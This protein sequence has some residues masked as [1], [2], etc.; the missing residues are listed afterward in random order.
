MLRLAALLAMAWAL[1][2]VPALCFAGVFLHPCDCGTSVDC[3]HEEDCSDDPCT[4]ALVR[5]DSQ[6][7]HLVLDILGT[8]AVMPWPEPVQ[9]PGAPFPAPA[10]NRPN[11][12]RPSGD[13]PLLI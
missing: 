3:A 1:M 11:L 13:L 10:V 12:P 6:G 7:G 4:D 5:Q 8:T 2:A 9:A